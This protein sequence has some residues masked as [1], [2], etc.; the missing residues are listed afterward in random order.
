MAFVIAPTELMKYA[1]TANTVPVLST[2]AEKH[3]HALTRPSC[4]M[5]MKTAVMDQTK[6]SAMNVQPTSV[7]MKATAAY[8]RCLEHQSARARS[9]FKELDVRESSYEIPQQTL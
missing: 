5:V 6:L 2:S 4:A 7:A 3:Q 9:A 1:E 8:I